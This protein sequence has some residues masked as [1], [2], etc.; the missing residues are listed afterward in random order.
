MKPTNATKDIHRKKALESISEQSSHIENQD[1]TLNEK[2]QPAKKRMRWAI[3][4]VLLHIKINI[5]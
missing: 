1:A 2:E 3:D 5:L 4:C